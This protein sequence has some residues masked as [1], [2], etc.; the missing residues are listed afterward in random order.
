MAEVKIR[1]TQSAGDHS[2]ETTFEA[3]DIDRLDTD[4]IKGL[5]GTQEA[6]R[7]PE[8]EIKLADVPTAQPGLKC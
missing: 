5:F 3:K 8:K 7:E 2:M 6:A 1:Q 4:L